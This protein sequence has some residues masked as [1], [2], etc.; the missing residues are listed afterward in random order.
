MTPVRTENHAPSPEQ[1]LFSGQIQGL[2][3]AFFQ[4]ERPPRGLAGRLDWY[5]QGAISKQL[6]SGAISGSAG[7]CVYF[8]IQKNQSTCHL[9]L[10]GCGEAKSPGHRAAVARAN[11]Q[12]LKKN[13]LSLQW[14]TTGISRSDFGN[15]TDLALETSLGGV[16]LWIAT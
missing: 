12:I 3:A 16:Q 6:Q 14:K 4:N 5:L 1:A 8:P 2:V 10:L 11:L 15:P 9:L 13:L 7:E